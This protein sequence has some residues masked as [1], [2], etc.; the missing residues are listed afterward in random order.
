MR[1]KQPRNIVVSINIG[2]SSGRDTLSG[3]FRFMNTGVRWRLQLINDPQDI[4]KDT[5]AQPDGIIAEF[6]QRFFSDGFLGRINC[7]VIF[8]DYDNLPTQRPPLAEFIK[9][10]DEEIGRRAFRHL[11]NLGS[12]GS[13]VFATDAPDT[14]WSKNRETGFKACANETNRYIHTL[15]IPQTWSDSREAAAF[16]AKL[17]RLPLPIAIFSAWDMLSLRLLDILAE[18]KIPVPDKAVV[19]GVDNDEIICR[20]STISLSSILP[21]HELLGFTAAKE[22]QRLINRGAPHDLTIASSVRDVLSR[23]STRIMQPAEHIIRT[24]K[25]YIAAHASENISPQDVVRHLGISRTLA[26][27]R[28]RE[29]NGR[30]IG[31]EIARVRI[32]EIKRQILSS[33]NTLTQIASGMGFSSSAALTRY[34]KRE[35]GVT[36][37]EWRNR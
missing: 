33:K 37:T 36:P 32:G 9:L 17:S 6:H 5:I 24:A 30:S 11:S 25:S 26:D 2:G 23:D 20:G 10:D 8:T 14:K 35:T 21:N 19:L 28:F 4:L 13:L 31:D 34:F 22:L 7:P 16:A 15:V 3:I 12:F 18:A 29:F 1:M 27:R